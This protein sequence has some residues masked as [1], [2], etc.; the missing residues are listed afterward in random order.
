MAV[1]GISVTTD[2]YDT[3]IAILK[4]R[5][6]NL[7]VLIFRH[8]EELYNLSPPSPNVTAD[9]WQLHNTLHSHVGSLQMIGV[10]G[11]Q[12]GV[13]LTRMVLGKL[14]VKCRWSGRVTAWER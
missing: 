2:H 3:A 9:M 11:S 7:Q 10:Q 1:R 12:Y 4:E 14:P 5:F 6:G 8:V 13:L